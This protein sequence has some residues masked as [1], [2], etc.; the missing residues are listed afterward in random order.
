M[1]KTWLGFVKTYSTAKESLVITNPLSP[2]PIAPLSLNPCLLLYTCPILVIILQVHQATCFVLLF[3]L[4]SDKLF[5]SLT[6]SH[7]GPLL[8]KAA[9]K[10][11]NKKYG[12]QNDR[13][14]TD[15]QDKD[16]LLAA[17]FYNHNRSSFTVPNMKG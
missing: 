3:G 16:L 8:G 2:V 7:P 4:L 17:Q 10:P 14:A 13:K 5:S 9:Y 6:V 12:K 1:T 11:N 15:A